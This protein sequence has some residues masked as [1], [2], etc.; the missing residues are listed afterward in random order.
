MFNDLERVVL[1]AIGM[2]FNVYPGLLHPRGSV[3]RPGP[4]PEGASFLH[5]GCAYG[6]H[7]RLS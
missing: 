4:A 6:G 2:D 5:F 1:L 3:A 7:E